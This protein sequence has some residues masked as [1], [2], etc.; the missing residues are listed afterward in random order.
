MTASPPTVVLPAA[1]VDPTWLGAARLADASALAG[2]RALARVASVLDVQGPE[3]RVPSD[4]GHLR[5]LQRHLELPEG[6]A[7]AGCTSLSDGRPAAAW[8]LDP[9]H[10]HI[11]RDHLVL[12]DPR[13]LGLTRTEAD[14]L[15]EAVAPLFAEDGLRLEQPTPARW[16]LTESDAARPLRLMT[17]PLA[18]AI[19]R[20]IEAWLPTGDDARRW[21]RLSNAVQMTWFEHPVN[22]MRQQTQRPTVNSLWI[23]GRCPS[24]FA[25]DAPRIR[26]AAQLAAH[27]GRSLHPGKPQGPDPGAGRAAPA[28]APAPAQMNGEVAL[29]VEPR[30]LDAQLAGDPL[31]WLDAWKSLD[32]AL[33]A[34]AAAGAAPWGDGVQLVLAGDAGW[35]TLSVTARRRWRF[36]S[37]PAPSRLLEEPS[38][39]DADPGQRR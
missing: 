23:E 26:T 11:G 27:L 15:A 18:G 13:T 1:L 2:W 36:W 37:R 38:G 4:P 5:W 34:P 12:T 29:S 30:L 3:T 31:R 9:V 22:L 28:P 32:E 7:L 24:G 35:R 14:G 17:R 10:L 21:R 6:I 19:G 33:F 20:S 39:P 8:R 25:L 16:Y